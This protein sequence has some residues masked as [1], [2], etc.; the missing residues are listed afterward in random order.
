MD[1][2]D[3]R[4][5]LVALKLNI[6]NA[7]FTGSL[8]RGSRWMN[9][10]CPFAPW[11]HARGSDSHP[12]FGI[13]VNPDSRSHYKCLACGV[14]GSLSSLPTKLGGY[15]KQ[16]YSAL[17]LD[18]E[19]MELAA[20]ANRPLPDWDDAI[21]PEGE[22]DHE[23]YLPNPAAL[24]SYPRAIGVPYLRQRGL[25][26]PAVYKLGLRYDAFQRRVL[27]P[28]F[29]NL[30]R[31]RGLTGRSTLSGNNATR[32]SNPKVRDY[33]RLPKRELFL[34]LPGP[35]KGRRIIGEGLFDYA[36]FVQAGFPASRAILGTSLTEE[37]VNT[38]IAEAEPVYFFMDNDLAG[39]IALFGTLDDD[40]EIMDTSNA[41]AFRLF[42][43]LPVWIVPYQK[44]L[45]GTDP[46]S[47]SSEQIRK[48]ISDAW[49]FTGNP[50][51]DDLGLPTFQ[52]PVWT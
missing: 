6:Q 38:L 27:F 50:P 25:L 12:S 31:F 19:M 21:L 34:G 33:Y 7:T 29:D 5:L 37:K 51:F 41:W 10:S 23:T 28:V 48:A 16:N 43:E 39:W 1:E 15:R 49:L 24:H 18:A 26:F 13:T 35:Q 46:G 8:K 32:G 14:K 30:D 2:P 9:I 36:K 42:E 22:A 47:L 40:Q 4:A 44:Q 3:I 52:P 20:G 11:T 17:R 45:D